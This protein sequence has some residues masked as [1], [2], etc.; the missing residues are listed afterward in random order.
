MRTSRGVFAFRA[1]DAHVAVGA[2]TDSVTAD[3]V[4]GTY[5]PVLGLAPALGRLLGPE[6][7]RTVGGH[8]VVVLSHRFFR[9]R[10]ASDPGVV[11]RT[12]NLN[13]QPMTVVGVAPAGFDGL[14][15]GQA[16]DLFV[17]LAMEPLVQPTWRPVLD[18]WRSRWLT[19]MGRL[20]PSETLA[21]AEA[22]TNVVYAQLLQEDVKTATNLSPRWREEFLKKRLVLQPGARGTSSLR[23]Q[24]RTPLLVLM[25][26][27]GLVLMIACA[28][29]ANLLLARGST[30]QKE[31][32]VRTA[33]GAG[34]GR[35]VRQLVVESLI[36]SIAGGA[37]GLALSVWIGQVLIAALPFDSATQVFSSD[38]DVRIALFAFGLAVVTG[39]AFGLVPALQATRRAIVTTLKNEATAVVGGAAPF[40]FRRGLVVAQIALSL[41]LLVGAG[42]FTRSLG[43]LRAL[44]PGFRPEHL[45]TF[46]VDPSL[47]GYEPGK[48][49]AL[50]ERLRDAL[51]AE[52]G[53]E[54]VSLAAL[55]LMDGSDASSTIMVEGYKEK[56]DEDMSPRFNWVGP[57]FFETTGMAV[58]RGRDLT[59]ADR[60]GTP[61][62][63]V[64]N[65]AF[66][67][68]FFGDQDP[69]GRRFGRARD[70]K[71]DTE[72]VGV[73]RDGKAS[74]LR[75]EM[76][77][78]VYA[79]AAQ[80]EA[81][82]ERT[83]YVRTAGDPDLLLGRVPAIV[84]SID[85][86][87]PVTQSR[88][89][90]AQIGQSLY[91]E[92]LVATLSAAFGLLATFLA[93]LGLYGVMAYAV[94]Q[95]TREIGIRMALGAERADV[96]RMVF[97]DV[98]LL[99]AAGV[100]IGLPGGYGLG[101]AIESQLFGL[102]ARDPLTFVIATL[103]LV[104]AAT[105]AAYVP[106][107]RATRVDPLVALRSE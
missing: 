7:D 48:R 33:L 37:V 94:S 12:L 36:L 104:G 14:E 93:A 96:L 15:V 40:R 76:Q 95:R 24:A 98:A 3:L 27:V 59:D 99:V 100:A 58:V 83:F 54:S 91:V 8:P 45:A 1:A 18:N 81:P 35:L 70:Q 65:E 80:Q 23:E 39:L 57:G 56:E 16:S 44:D 41:L 105:A 82:G 72:I 74:S 78:F 88:T 63:A 101:R 79:P 26:M 68:Y 28:N 13:G 77:R 69:V 9:T 55:A 107:R 31:L 102:H 53:V 43:N 51:R 47:S 22:S 89:M 11:G 19:V 30:R 85:P 25:G 103:A 60:V 97:R 75:E 92:R 50:Y 87:L 52:P 73:V 17:P 5:F 6:D 64:V 67:R 49:A 66:A 42:L 34:R 32:A 62:V 86:S 2:R 84:R 10:F 90:R 38:A 106:A 71:T 20:K 21:S 61:K 46:R 29:V 4:S